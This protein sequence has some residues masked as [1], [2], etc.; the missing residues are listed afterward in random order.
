MYLDLKVDPGPWQAVQR[1][2]RIAKAAGISGLQF[3]ETRQV[4]WASIAAAAMAAPG[5]DLA[6]GVAVAFPRSPMI[7]ALQAW[8]LAENTQGHFRL[9]LGSQVSAHVRRRFSAPFDPP[10][11]R[12]HDYIKAV[13]AC[14]SAFRGEQALAHQGP[15]YSLNLLPPGW[16]PRRHEHESIEISIAAVGPAMSRLAGEVADGVHVNPVH[17]KRYLRTRLLPA[18]TEGAARA[19]RS[20]K[21]VQVVVH[22]WAVPGD[23]PE[24]R[25]ALAGRVKSELAFYGTTPN[26]SFQFDDAGF[27]GAGALLRER[28]RRGD[29][30]GMKS[31]ITDAML[32]EYAVVCRWD[33]LPGELLARYGGIASRLVVYLAAELIERDPALAARWGEVARALGS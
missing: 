19:G 24:E 15:F 20:V 8:E 30:A 14:F 4:P 29:T 12:M 18:L 11:S 17:S 32:A 9:G 28:L 3:T 31:L 7:T 5:L 21:Q 22:L 6:T 1:F 23:T 25:A 26:Y 33:D 2:A 10:V 16:A 13:R 27:P